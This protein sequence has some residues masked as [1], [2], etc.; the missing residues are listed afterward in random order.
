MSKFSYIID[1]IHGTEFSTHP[2][3]HL[4]VPDLFS[5]DHFAEI[6]SARE[7][8]LRQAESDEDLISVLHENKFKE[9]SFPGTTTD[10][11]V[12]LR[13]HKAFKEGKESN[14]GLCDGFGVTMR[15]QETDE[16]SILREVADFFKS[17]EFWAAL[18]SK[19]EIRR[20]DVRVDVGLQK[21]LDGYEISPHPDIRLKAMTFMINL[22][23]AAQSEN[24][25]YHTSYL[26]FRPEKD[27]VRQ[28]WIENP[29][30]DRF[31]VPWAWCDVK[32]KQTKNNSVVIFSPADDTMHAVRAH[33]DH[34]ATQRTQFYGNLWYTKANAKSTHTWADFK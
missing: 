19:F 28:F 11:P 2:F 1:R 27:H 3:K 12:Y 17:P 29:T 13:W 4:Y 5:A 21:Y 31:W 25:D 18:T 7:V 26:T 34:L 16:G 15:L 14:N 33:Y 10:L 23:P 22:N 6:T 8:N 9:I 32:T 24:I 20:T 30:I